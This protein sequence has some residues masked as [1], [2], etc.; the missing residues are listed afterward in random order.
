[1]D[2]SLL[3]NILNVNFSCLYTMMK[4]AGIRHA[5]TGLRDHKMSSSE[6]NWFE[7][8]GKVGEVDNIFNYISPNQKLLWWAFFG[9]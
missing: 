1:M 9:T 8:D 5:I 6:E 7:I 2:A 4:A 3:E